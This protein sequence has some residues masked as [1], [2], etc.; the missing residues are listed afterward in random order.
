[1]AC[2]FVTH[3]L[4]TG[5]VFYTF[6]VF[7]HPLSDHFGWTR[8]EISFGFSMAAVLGALYA[9]FVGR[10]VDRGGPKPV[11]IFGAVMLGAA[12]F[13]L[14]AVE[15]LGQYYLAMGCLVAAGSTCLGPVTSNAAVTRW[16]VRRRGRALGIATAGI[17]M[18]GVIFV[19]LTQYLIGSIGWRGAFV[20]IGVIVVAVGVPP[21]WLWM[22]RSPEEMGLLPDGAVPREKLDRSLLE[23]EL[24]RSFTARD[25]VR[26]R[27]FWLIA[28]AFAMTVSGLS[29]VLLHQIPYLIDEGMDPGVA[30]WMLGG[31]AGVGVLGKLGFGTLIDRFDQRRV[32]LFCFALQAVG[33]VLLFFVRSPLLLFLYVV[34]Y[35]YSMGGNATLQATIV[36]E[37]FGRLHY[38]S[39]AGRMS[40]ILVTCQALGVPLVGWIHDTTGSYV[41]A[42]AMIVA[43][44]GVAAICIWN[45]ELPG[46]R[47]ALLTTVRAVEAGTG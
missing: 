16:F 25:A 27:N 13:A 20:V 46:R 6:G 11:Q 34:V 43:A 12:Y 8:A 5:T 23:A 3:C 32:T 24:E 26:T 19:P 18:G 10:F 36:G 37:C 45:L 15:S 21:V 38:G 2:A 35:G 17:S 29:A 40:P 1:V 4:T 30:S 9:P 14:A 42:F 28:V 39:I 41:A 31:T 47:A 33:V 7:F 22:R 44:T